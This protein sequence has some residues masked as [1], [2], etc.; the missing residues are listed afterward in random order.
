MD[1]ETCVVLP[2]LEDVGVGKEGMPAS[3]GV[4]IR[5]NLRPD[6]RRPLVR[7]RLTGRIRAEYREMPGLHLTVRQAARLFD[8]DGGRCRRVLDEC[9]HDGWLCSQPDGVYALRHLA[10]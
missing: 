7:D 6:R 2:P 1:Q 10:R 9:V 3:A 8:V 5:L 4:P